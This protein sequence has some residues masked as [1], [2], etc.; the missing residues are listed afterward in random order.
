LDQGVKTLFF[1]TLSCSG[2]QF[3]HQQP[4]CMVEDIGIKRQFELYQ[5]ISQISGQDIPIIDSNDVLKDPERMLRLLC[6][7]LGVEF[8]PA[9]LNWPQGRREKGNPAPAL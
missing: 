2:R 8:M 5:E 3:I 1:D 4:G 6:D 9:M 7:K